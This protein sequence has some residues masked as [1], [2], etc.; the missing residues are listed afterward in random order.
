MS[1][2]SEASSGS[3]GCPKKLVGAKRFV[4]CMALFTSVVSI[5][6]LPVLLP[7]VQAQASNSAVNQQK[8]SSAL[9]GSAVDLA[10][11][12]I[13]GVKVVI[14]DL[15]TKQSY[16]ASSDVS[17]AFHFSAVPAGQYRL[18]AGKSGYNSFLI[19]TMPLM[20]G[21]VVK[22][23]IKMQAGSA[24]EVVE[25]G[26]NSAISSSGALLA[27]KVLNDIPENQRNFVNIVQLSNGANEGSTNQ[28][29][30]Y[31]PGAQ[32]GSSSVSVGGQLELLNNV[33]LDGVDNIAYSNGTIAVHPSV[34][35]IAGMQVS[36]SAYSASLGRA[37]GGVINVSTRSGE[38]KFHGTVYEYLRNDALDTHP[39]MFGA[40]GVRKPE[41]RQN[42]FGGAIDGPLWKNRTTFFAD[43]EGFR[44]LQ[45]RPPSKLTVPTAYEHDNPGDF[46]DIGGVTLTAAEMD[47]VGLQYFKLFPKPNTGGTTSTSFI[48]VPVASNF[49]HIGDLRIDHKISQKDQFFGRFSYN[50]MTVNVP[51]AFP[52]VTMDGL[53]IYPRGQQNPSPGT[54][55]VDSLNQILSYTRNFS[56][57]LS[58]NL[59]AGYVWWDEK[60][61]AL[62]TGNNL[63]AAF[64]QPGVNVDSSTTGLAPVNVL[65][66]AV[67]GNSGYNR[68]LAQVS[69]AFNYKG[70]VDWQAGKHNLAIGAGM[71]RRLWSDKWPGGDAL[72][73]WNVVDLPNLLEGN[74]K[75]V[76]QMRNLILP[77][78]RFFETNAYAQ[79]EWR[80]TSDL[81]ITVGVRYD[82][83]TQPVEKRNIMSNFDS[84]TGAIL[85]AGK[86][87]VSASAV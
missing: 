82:V 3:R 63:N 45:G 33:L 11:K 83:F 59:K 39:F 20:E 62:N 35:A 29:S 26:T 36:G 75:Q 32:H 50:A 77:H 78:Y 5:A 73:Y 10:G 19:K 8:R 61:G 66:A 15:D 41:V 69:N 72:G 54:K 60:A 14:T 52:A 7:Q 70:E 46:S 28:A 58:M 51:G 22:A 74:F 17:G 30:N 76:V 57:T 79:D 67:L 18:E 53:T 84:K 43:Y 38:K 27:G 56:K 37:G 80:A 55:T 34:D 86:D 85:V 12:A 4:H 49:T 81:S 21:D 40:T 47:K 2:F 24:S 71:V 31:S 42:Q 23:T 64:G 6:N 16:T 1:Y 65:A 48:S 87:G 44:L 68:P 9:N 25:G 13:G